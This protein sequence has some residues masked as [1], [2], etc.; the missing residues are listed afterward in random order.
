MLQI[1]GY[2]RFTGWHRFGEPI[3]GSLQFWH[4][5]GIPRNARYTSDQIL[6]V[7][8]VCNE[9]VKVRIPNHQTYAKALMY[10]MGSLLSLMAVDELQLPIYPAEE[11][12][13][14][15]AAGLYNYGRR[16]C[17]DDRFQK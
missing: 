11:I 12:M 7:P 1:T 13:R 10:A 17:C 4:Q 6:L 16:C 2:Q 9:V 14:A 3:A 5:C 15:A 8:L